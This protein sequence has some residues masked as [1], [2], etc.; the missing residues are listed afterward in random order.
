MSTGP[1]PGV[2]SIDG[3]NAQIGAVKRSCV[4]D[5]SST[6]I[7]FFRQYCSTVCVMSG[8]LQL[9]AYARIM[10]AQSDEGARDANR[11]EASPTMP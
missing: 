3:Q 8:S 5:E 10:Q 6:A 1:H 2:V 7:R 9:W 4:W 11:R